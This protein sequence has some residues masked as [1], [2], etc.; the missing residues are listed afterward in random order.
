MEID[1]EYYMT[2]RQGKNEQDMLCAE[3]DGVMK[4]L[5]KI[6]CRIAEGGKSQL[7]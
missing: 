2:E 1:S 4:R 6:K 7:F 3:T 5:L